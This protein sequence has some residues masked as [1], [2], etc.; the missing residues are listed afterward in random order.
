MIQSATQA[1]G[2]LTETC[3]SWHPYHGMSYGN[4]LVQAMDAY[5]LLV[6]QGCVYG[7]GMSSGTGLGGCAEL[8]CITN[9]FC[10]DENP[11]TA[12]VCNTVNGTCTHTEIPGCCAANEQCDDG[13]PCTEDVCN[14][15]VLNCTHTEI[16]GCCAANE[17][18]DDGDPCTEDVCDTDGS[19]SNL[20]HPEF[21]GCC[22]ADEFCDDG[23]PCTDNVCN[24]ED[25]TCT[26]PSNYDLPGCVPPCI[27]IVPSCDKLCDAADCCSCE[28]K[29][30]KCSGQ[31]IQVCKGVYQ[32]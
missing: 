30:Q 10:D 25:G 6:L 19:C 5:D 7:D 13:N 3:T 23:D 11:C 27:A 26:N 15:T 4:G 2:G 22:T 17:Q 1:I 32:S 16:P 12:D 20:V 21:S 24:T 18:C 28:N 14:T 9:E 29:K 31:R 8:S